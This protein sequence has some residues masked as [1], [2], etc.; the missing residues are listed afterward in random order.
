[1]NST[2]ASSTPAVTAMTM[3]K[4]TVSVKQVSS[5]ATSLFGATL[6]VCTKCSTSD[7]FHATSSSNAA[8][9]AMGRYASA[10][11]STTMASSTV[12]ACVIAER[13]ERPPNLKFEAVRAI[14]PV[15]G[16]PPKK[17]VSRLPMPRAI[18]SESGS[19]RV[20]AMPSAT[21]AE[22]SDSMAAS[23][24]M[25]KALGSRLRKTSSDIPTGLPST[26]GAFHGSVNEGNARGM[27]SMVTPSSTV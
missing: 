3:S 1:M 25:V 14:A 17:G 2:D 9:L 10:G 23:I 26:P 7:M 21:T 18:N 24:A 5:T 13:G 6:M 19:C 22:S 4:S 20:R 15:A 11:A 12:T 27:P 8:R 16:M